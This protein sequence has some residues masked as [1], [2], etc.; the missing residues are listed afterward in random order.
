MRPAQSARVSVIRKELAAR[1]EPA[2]TAQSALLVARDYF[3][4]DS[5]TF[6]ADVPTRAT[7]SFS[8]SGVI[9]KD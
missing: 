5:R 3:L 1:F 9:P 2:R 4:N 6:C 8:C 7:A